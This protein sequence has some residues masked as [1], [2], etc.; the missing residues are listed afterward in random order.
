[1]ADCLIA[2]GSNLGRRSDALR[3]AVAKLGDNPAVRVVGQSHWRQTAP[4]GGPAG[5][6]RFVNGA[7]RIET[8]LTPPALFALL[9]QIETSLGRERHERWADRSI[10]LDLLLYDEQVIATEELIVPHPRMAFRRFVLEGAAEVAADMRH[11]QIGWTI[12]QLLRHL[13]TA[14]NYV[15]ITGLP[16]AGQHELARRLHEEFGGGE[17]GAGGSGGGEFGGRLLS[18]PGS[19][20]TDQA[21]RSQSLGARLEFLERRVAL[22]SPAKLRSELPGETPGGDSLLVSDFWLGESLAAV[23]LVADADDRDTLSAQWEELHRAAVAPKLIVVLDAPTS[24][25]TQ[26]PADDA[27]DG[28]PEEIL[29]HEEI[30]DFRRA[31]DGLIRRGGHGPV[32]RLDATREDLV[33]QEASAAVC[34]MQ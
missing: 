14:A 7:V 6:G 2:L 34:A 30:E 32:L 9:Q 15:A 18:D 5:Q 29:S 3:A 1:M 21:V 13:D 19:D 27:G 11:P 20:R 4:V 12:G 23:D 8:S 24:F 26:R 33:W 25:L 10:N 31:L 28:P 17:F 22:L 16:G